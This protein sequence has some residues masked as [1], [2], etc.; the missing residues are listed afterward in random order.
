MIGDFDQLEQWTWPGQAYCY[1]N[2]GFDL[3]GFVIETITGQ[4]Y[5][6]ILR[7]TVFQPAGVAARF[8]QEIHPSNAVATGHQ[9]DADNTPVPLPW[10][11]AKGRSSHPSGGLVISAKDLLTISGVLLSDRT[12]ISPILLSPDTIDAMWTPIS[13]GDMVGQSHGLGWSIHETDAGRVVGHTGT[14]PGFKSVLT[15]LPAQDAALVVLA[16]TDDDNA[17]PEMEAWLL[18]HIFGI[19]QKAAVPHGTAISLGY[20]ADEVA[21]VYGENG[22]TAWAIGREQGELVFGRLQEPGM[23]IDW[24]GQ[25]EPIAPGRF[26][27]LNGSGRFRDRA[28]TVSQLPD[29]ARG[30]E[31]AWFLYLGQSFH[32]RRDG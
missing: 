16:N 12:R 27:V 10:G 11:E 4:P 1:N 32:R 24:I 3:T 7:R 29:A 22:S 13:G 30:G 21:G 25:L 19:R 2:H 6:D 17:V 23:A 15:L 26:R 28:I 18:R 5:E 20:G 14:N 9:L 8:I 31:P